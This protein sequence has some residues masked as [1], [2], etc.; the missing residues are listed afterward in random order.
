MALPPAA[1]TVG[2]GETQLKNPSNPLAAENRR[3]AI[4]NM[5]DSKAAE[6]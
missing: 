3:V 6:N 1:A 2:Y 4:V 5:V